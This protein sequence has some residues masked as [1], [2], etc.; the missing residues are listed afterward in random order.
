VNIEQ[1]RKLRTTETGQTNLAETEAKLA[2]LM[3]NA[4]RKTLTR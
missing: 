2:M 3:N 4:G 1:N